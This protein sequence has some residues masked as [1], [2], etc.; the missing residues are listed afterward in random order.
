MS[1]ND[2]PAVPDSA[3]SIHAAQA[4]ALLVTALD[5]D[6]EKFMAAECLRIVKDSDFAAKVIAEMVGT[7]NALLVGLAKATGHSTDTVLRM[8]GLMAARRAGEHDTDS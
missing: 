4:V 2:D 6:D 5:N 1:E 7:I 8:Y 3:P